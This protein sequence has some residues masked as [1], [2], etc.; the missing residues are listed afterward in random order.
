LNSAEE[1][2]RQS[3]LQLDDEDN[4]DKVTGEILGVAIEVYK[5]PPS[6]LESTHEWY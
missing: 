2:D 6:L 3:A 5:V 4:A 1:I